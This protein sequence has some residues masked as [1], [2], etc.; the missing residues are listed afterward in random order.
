MMRRIWRLLAGHRDFRYVTTAGL[1]SLTGDWILRI[2][3][4]YRVYAL[5]DSTVAS[6]LT[7]ISSYVPQ[8]ILGSV[9]GVFADRWD[10]K[11][12][13]VVAD[14]L[15][16]AGLLPLIVVHARSE[17][18]VVFAVLF[19][20]GIV[21]Q[22]FA[23]AEQA[24]LP[25][26]VPDDQL[27]SA[28]ALNGQSGNVSRLAGSALGGV[29]AAFGGIPALGLADAASFI[30]S[31]ACIAL[32]RAS[33]RA[34]RDAADEDLA[35]ALRGQVASIRRDLRDGLRLSVHKPF[36]RVLLIFALVT[37][38]GEGIMTTLF[39]PFVRHVLLGTSQAY[40]F[41]AA[42][43]AVGGIAG[44]L[45]AAAVGARFRASFLFAVGAICFGAVDLAI[46]LYPL[47]YVAVWPAAVGMTIVGFPGALYLAGLMTLFQRNTDDSYRGRIFGTLSAVE[48]VA[49]M[50]GAAGGGYLAEFTGIIP[51][52]AIQGAS[53]ALAGLGVLFWMRSQ[54]ASGLV[55][56]GPARLYEATATE[57]KVVPT[58][59]HSSG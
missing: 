35:G 30:A 9:A 22:F 10:R 39:A 11:K 6:A 42:A 12:T 1:I 51:V 37:S 29:V 24:L 25:R 36:L 52:L 46:F 15:L 43:Q 20:E 45:L 49:I 28:N 56:P 32:I 48:G 14:L 38:L 53:Y 19:W 16:A 59:P 2:G 34:E 7:I 33:G 54:N 40:G 4:V 57:I 26:L 3:L 5:T 55:D 44:G 58:Q 31:A 13:M 50:A 27:L 47:G 18:W 23:P 8:V 21:Q 41:V 17:V